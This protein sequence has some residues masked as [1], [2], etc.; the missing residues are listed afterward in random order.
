MS[1]N[2]RMTRLKR[3]V[4]GWT[5]YFKLG[6]IGTVLKQIDKGLETG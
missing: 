5:N 1:F 4:H 3:L 6:G 2:E